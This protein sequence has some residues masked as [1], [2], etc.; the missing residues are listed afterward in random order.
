[1]GRH[2][3]GDIEGKFMFGAQASNDADFFGVEGFTHEELCYYFDESNIP[4]IIEG[5]KSCENVLGKYLYE[6]EIYDKEENPSK[7]LSEYLKINDSKKYHTLLQ[8]SARKTLGDK[9]LKCVIESGY[10]EFSAEL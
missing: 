3:F 2:Y 4:S 5:L 1:M 6:I 9:I 8:W 10:C 7:G